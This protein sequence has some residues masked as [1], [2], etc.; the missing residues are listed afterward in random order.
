MRRTDGNNFLQA[1]ERSVVLPN[2]RNTEYRLQARAVGFGEPVEERLPRCG[3]GV[4]QRL[5][6]G[7]TRPVTDEIRGRVLQ[8]GLFD[9]RAVLGDFRSSQGKARE[10]KVIPLRLNTL[11]A[12][13][14]GQ[15]LRQ[16]AVRNAERHARRD[17]ER[18]PAGAHLESAVGFDELW[19]E[20]GGGVG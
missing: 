6:V 14:V 11:G 5:W 18:E 19:I 20:A 3:L 7:L 16:T 10:R 13:L 1:L 4:A 12:P 17:H 9:G 2:R 15:R 8:H